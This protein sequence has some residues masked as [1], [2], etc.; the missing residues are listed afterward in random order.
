MINR[1]YPPSY[2]SFFFRRLMLILRRR[3]EG[4]EIKSDVKFS[5]LKG[6]ESNTLY[7]NKFRLCIRDRKKKRSIPPPLRIVAAT[8]RSLG[9]CPGNSERW[10]GRIKTLFVTCWFLLQPRAST[11]TTFDSLQVEIRQTDED[12]QQ[13]KGNIS[14]PPPSP[15]PNTHCNKD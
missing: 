2:K 10:G 13:N 14:P 9:R 12:T 3:G 11:D 1:S 5:S 4:G 15:L 6:E 8:L 7:L